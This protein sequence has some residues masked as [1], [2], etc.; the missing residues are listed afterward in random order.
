MALGLLA[1][2][3]AALFAGAALYINIAEHPARMRLPIEAALAQWKIA[4]GRGALMQA[5]LA[6]LGGLAAIGAAVSADWRFLIG[7]V[8]LL[9]NWPYT[10]F[11]VMPA[12][13]RLMALGE[14]AIAEE[15][16]ALLERWALLHAARSLLGVLAAAALVW[17][18][19]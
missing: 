7:G 18:A 1:L 14:A 3:I 5:G 13:K 2:A 6:L 10:L 17:A 12:N 8:L 11:V 9:A 16:R 19:L 4:Y 15:T